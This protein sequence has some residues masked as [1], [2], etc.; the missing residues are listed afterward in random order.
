VL[1][2]P[3]AAAARQP[4]TLAVASRLSGLRIRGPVRTIVESR[5]R[6]RADATRAIDRSYPIAL[7]RLDATFYGA[8]GVDAEA[9]QID[10]LLTEEAVSDRAFYDPVARAVRALRSPAPSRAELVDAYVRALV[11][12]NFG[13]RRITTLRAQPGHVPRGERPRRRDRIAR[14]AHPRDRHRSRLN[15]TR[16]LPLAAARRR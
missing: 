8:L 13:L 4:S 10:E 11:D 12:Q 2:A 6:F 3:S 7:R 5:A 16:P 9:S 14:V 15:P 1:L